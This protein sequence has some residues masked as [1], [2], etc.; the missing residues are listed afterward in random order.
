MSTSPSVSVRLGHISSRRCF[1]PFSNSCLCFSSLIYGRTKAQ[2]VG[3]SRKM[4]SEPGKRKLRRDGQFSLIYRGGPLGLRTS[5]SPI[6]GLHVS[7][8][9]Q[10]QP[11]VTSVLIFLQSS[12]STERPFQRSTL[13]SARAGRGYYLSVVTRAK[14]GRWVTCGT[15][16]CSPSDILRVFG[17]VRIL[18]MRLN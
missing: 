6:L 18:V 12:M 17:N 13:T 15:D 7:P 9:Y 8:E 10:P 1:L 2:R 11:L 3:G 14:H 5:L 16:L 4:T